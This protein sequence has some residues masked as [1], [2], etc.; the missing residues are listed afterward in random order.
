MAPRLIINE[1]DS[2]SHSN[3]DSGCC[4]G[5][6]GLLATP[7]A[8]LAVLASPILSFVGLKQANDVGE[9]EEEQGKMVE[10]EEEG[11]D[12]ILADSL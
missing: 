8:V 10:A 7:R 4:G 3:S 9:A 2:N 1:D 11:D 5:G 12:L 6:G